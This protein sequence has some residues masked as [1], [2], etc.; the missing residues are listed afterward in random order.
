[1]QYSLY[2]LAAILVAMASAANDLIRRARRDAGLTQAQLATRMGTTQTAVARMERRGA[3][4]TVATLSR[5]LGA[6]GQQLTLD[7]SPLP[8]V[9][10]EEQLSAHLRLTPSE[11][12]SA[13]DAAYR[14]T[15]RMMRGI[16]GVR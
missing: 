8:T 16:A 1:M 12:V 4:P 5:A 9:V 2:S 11:R 14:N 3:N 7:S 13:H 10:D 15:A 6:A